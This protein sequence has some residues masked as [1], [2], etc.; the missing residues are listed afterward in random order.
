MLWRF[1]CV[2]GGGLRGV[3]ASDLC[4]CSAEDLVEVLMLLNGVL[5]S[6]S[7]PV[8]PS[9]CHLPWKAQHSTLLTRSQYSTLLTTLHTPSHTHNTPPSSQHSTHPHTL[10]HTSERSPN[11]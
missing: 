8:Q 9:L 3:T 7:N 5:Q 11:D 2:C 10:T 1:V 6:V 4:I